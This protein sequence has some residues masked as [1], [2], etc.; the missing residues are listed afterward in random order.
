MATA[1]F[2]NRSVKTNDAD[3]ADDA[4]KTNASSGNGATPLVD[5]FRIAFTFL[6]LGVVMSMAGAWACPTFVV[7][8]IVCALGWELWWTFAWAGGDSYHERGGALHPTLNWIANSMGDALICVFQVWLV[9]SLKWINQDW[10]CRFDPKVLLVFLVV[11]VL[12]NVLLALIWE[13]DAIKPGA[14]TLS[15]APL[16][17]IRKNPALGKLGFQGQEPWLLMPLVLYGIILGWCKIRG[18]S[19]SFPIGP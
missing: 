4:Y 9:M 11:G 2:M 5:A 12:Q 19:V 7:M 6:A 16:S 18:D 14:P 8:F 15:W 17:P 1:L 13:N 3:E 10:Y